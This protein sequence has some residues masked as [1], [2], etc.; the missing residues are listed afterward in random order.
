MS[1]IKPLRFGLL[2]PPAARIWLVSM[3]SL[4]AACPG[5]VTEIC[6][7]ST[8]LPDVEQGFGEA[9]RS[10]GEAFREA[11]TWAPA[12]SSTIFI[13]TLTML[14][15]NDET[16]VVVDDLIADGAFPICVAQGA[17][18]ETSGQA[19]LVEGGFVTDATHEGGVAILGKDG[20]DLIGRFS[21]DLIGGGTEL[22]FDDGVFRVP[23]Q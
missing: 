4:V 17:R 15:A 7:Q 23:Q 2:S 22:S 13:G 6:G 20:D 14:I 11:G 1:V 21:F 16:G 5:P 18:S 9:T 19:N 10:D 12:P 3:A 8:E